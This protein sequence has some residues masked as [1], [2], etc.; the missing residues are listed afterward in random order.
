MAKRKQN[1]I[2]V[3]V[4]QM[5]RPILIPIFWGMGKAYEALF[6]GSDLRSS[7]SS[8]AQFEQAIRENLR[9]LFEDYSA[10]ITSDETIKH[11][12]PFDY[13][14]AI[15]SAGG[16]AF[17]FI[18]GRGE[19]RV[20]IA[21]DPKGSDWEE[22]PTVLQIIDEQFQR[23][24]FSSFMDIESALKPRMAFLQQSFSAAHKPAL[25]QRLADA[26]CHEKAVIRQW[27]TE[28][29]RRLPER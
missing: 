2:L 22:L 13:A 9:F 8:E 16:L 1:T 23:S 12:R 5:A 26:H 21:M 4:L 27:E 6:G 24:E 18:K 29:N 14:I 19:F 15:V 11:P 20:Q 7:R 25:R 10:G 17:R 3:T 28:I